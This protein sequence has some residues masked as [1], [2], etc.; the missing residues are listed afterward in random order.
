MGML[1]PALRR[2]VTTA[3]FQDFQERLLHA[4]SRN[5][6]RN[7]DVVRLAADLIDFIDINDPDLGSLHVVIGVLQKPQD[8]ILDILSDVTGF[9]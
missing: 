6:T 3:A 2:H 4:F 1:S 7:T 8:D 5:I 9:R